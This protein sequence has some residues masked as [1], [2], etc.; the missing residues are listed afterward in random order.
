[1]NLQPDR[2]SARFAFCIVTPLLLTLATVTAAQTKDYP[3]PPKSSLGQVLGRVS[4]SDTGEPIPKAQVQ[5]SPAD[6]ETSKTAGPERI[7]RTSPDGTFVFPDLPAG[8]Y[9]VTVW[10]NGF[11]GFSRH[12]D[13]DGQGRYINLKPGQKLENLDLRLDPTGVIA[14]Q[15]SDEDQEPVQGLAVFALRITFQTGGRK[16]VSD[17]GRSVTDDLGNFRLPNLPP[18]SYYVSAGGLIQRPMREVGLK[19]GP[20]GGMHYRN[21]FYPGTPSL[22]EA[23]ALRVGPDLATN[24]I[25]FTVPTERTYAITSKVLT[26]VGQPALKDAEVSCERV[27]A[28]GYTFEAAGETVQLESDHSFMFSSLYPGDY[29]LSV[30]KIVEGALTDLGFASVRIVGSNV[31]TNIEVGRAAEVH[32]RVQGSQGPAVTGKKI[33]LEIFGSGF[34]LLH[35][36][37]PLEASGRFVITNLPPGEYTF[38]IYNRPSEQPIYIKKAVCGGRD[39]AGRV[40]S[41]AIGTTLDCD[42]VLDNDTSVI[43]G[44]VKSG[45]TPVPGVVVVLIPASGDLRRVPRYTLTAKTDA[46][47]RYLI[48]GVIPADYLLFAAPPSLDHGYLAFDFPERHTDVAERVNVD[49]STTQA[50]NLTFSKLKQ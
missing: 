7:V 11:S 13:S 47:G 37:P 17:S 35:Q 30:K 25:R 10:H 41:L 12:E 18:G 28:A 27:D 21:T 8:T 1:M 20:S 24:D 34:Y 23:Q 31:R 6:P 44:Q 26:S 38:A 33:T 42:V 40:F 16:Q 29:T 43:H 15:V 2:R 9:G 14:G 32:G 46:A 36:S 22:D 3:Q 49:P 50:V 19:Q 39:Y 4:R 48:A 5:L 45:E